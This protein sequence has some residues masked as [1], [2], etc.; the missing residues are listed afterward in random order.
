MPNAVRLVVHCN[1]QGQLTRFEL[2]ASKEGFCTSGGPPCLANWI[3]AYEGGRQLPFEL[4]EPDLSP[5]QLKVLKY[6]RDIP[7]GQTRTY[8]EVAEAI[9]HPGAARA[10]GS[11]CGGNPFPLI[12]PCHRIIAA[13]GKIGGFGYGTRMKRL[14]LDHERSF[15]ITSA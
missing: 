6:L 3:S 14:L 1:A 2:Q 9:G 11:A 4:P 7:F 8:G 10:V 12:I 15:G 5:F 13:G